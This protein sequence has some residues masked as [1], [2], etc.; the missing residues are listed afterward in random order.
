MVK[1]RQRQN[2]RFWWLFVF[3]TI[4][5]SRRPLKMLQNGLK[6]VGLRTH[7][8]KRRP[9]AAIV[10]AGIVHTDLLLFREDDIK[11]AVAAVY[12]IFP[13]RL[14][15]SQ[16]RESAPTVTLQRMLRQVCIATPAITR[17]ALHQVLP[18]FVH[19]RIMR[20]NSPM[21]VICVSASAGIRAGRR[22]QMFFFIHRTPPK[23]RRAASTARGR[24]APPLPRPRCRFP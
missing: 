22:R 20:D 13:R 4:K 2:K 3:N 9:T 19:A 24:P 14:M 17:H 11:D 10:W 21:V 18:V 8:R 7:G 12:A 23:F 15:V 5:V 16:H 1:S 6:L